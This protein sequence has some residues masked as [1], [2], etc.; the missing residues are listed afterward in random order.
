MRSNIHNSISNHS[1]S[2]PPLFVCRHE[3]RNPLFG[4]Q[5]LGALR[6]QLGVGPGVPSRSGRI[7]DK[8]AGYFPEGTFRKIPDLSPL[9][10]YSGKEPY[11]YLQ[12]QLIPCDDYPV[13]LDEKYFR[14][15]SDT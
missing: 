13:P 7:I 9:E 6:E 1:E 4:S 5:V 11:P 15:L 8:L 2:E 14:N 12:L 3:D 10:I